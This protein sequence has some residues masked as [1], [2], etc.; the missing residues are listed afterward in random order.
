[1]IEQKP[2]ACVCS[3]TGKIAPGAGS[4]GKFGR[5][6]SHGRQPKFAPPGVPWRLKSI[7]SIAPCPTSPIARSPVARS[8]E[9]RHGLRSPYA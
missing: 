1:M 9:N 6:P 3:M 4:P 7:S 5:R 8:N 2:E